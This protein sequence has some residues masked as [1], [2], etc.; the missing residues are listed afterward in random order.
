MEPI[1]LILLA[2]LAGAGTA[3]VVVEILSWRAVD[4]YIRSRSAASGSAEIIRKRLASGR[5]E[6]VVG[7]FTPL[8][9]KVATQ[10]WDARALDPALQDRFCGRNVIKIIT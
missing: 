7:V 2:L 8:G 9:A 6:V 4:S 10:S 3:A 5:Y 1:T